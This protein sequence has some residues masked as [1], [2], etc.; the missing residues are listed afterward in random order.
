[1]QL[2]FVSYDQMSDHDQV[3]KEPFKSMQSSGLTSTVA[4][5]WSPA[6]NGPYEKQLAIGEE[7]QK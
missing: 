2:K 3:W 1:M 5:N 7:M 4:P 6:W